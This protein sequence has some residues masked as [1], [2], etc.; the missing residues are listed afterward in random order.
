MPVADRLLFLFTLAPIFGC[1]LIPG[2]FFA[3]SA[4]VMKTLARLPAEKGIAAMQSINIAVLNPQFLG[5]FL[6]TAAACVLGIVFSLMR[7]Q[8]SGGLC[9]RRR[10]ALSVRNVLGDNSI[11]HPAERG[12]CQGRS[13]EPGRRRA[14][15]R[16]LDQ[17][18][19]LT[20]SVP[21]PQPPQCY[22]SPCRS[23]IERSGKAVPRYS[24]I[25]QVPITLWVG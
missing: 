8:G 11:Q 24:G 2:G 10:R 12:A 4:F 9:A 16:V 25:L 13:A 17:A 1:G 23:S 19:G 20:T 18:D 21:P 14:V 7:W 5:V 15:G 22:R 6:G 3:S